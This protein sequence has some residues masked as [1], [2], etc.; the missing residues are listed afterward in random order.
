[1]KPVNLTQESC[2]LKSLAEIEQI[3]AD[4][5][6]QTKY[7]AR[8]YCSG[9]D[10]DIHLVYRDFLPAITVEDYLR[11]HIPNVAWIEATRFYTDKVDKVQRKELIEN[12]RCLW[13]YD[14]HGNLCEMD[15]LVLYEAF[16]SDKV[17]AGTKVSKNTMKIDKFK[18]PWEK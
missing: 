12:A 4:Y 15:G 2:P 16:M 7:E 5:M 8:V 11:Q 6:G 3:I 1:M 9:Y 18:L 14:V 13:L 10:V 17:L